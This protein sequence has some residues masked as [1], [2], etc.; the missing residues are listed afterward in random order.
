MKHYSGCLFFYT[1]Y[2]FLR[3]GL[4]TTHV[5]GEEVRVHCD[6]VHQKLHPLWHLPHVLF[7]SAPT[8]LLLKQRSAP[9]PNRPKFY[10]AFIIITIISISYNDQHMMVLN[11]FKA[12]CWELYVKYLSHLPSPASQRVTPFY[13][14]KNWSSEKLPSVLETQ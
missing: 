9:H 6:K 12:L 2:S 5:V 1:N 10:T 11:I 7:Y 4:V 14:S 3:D 13:R 8:V